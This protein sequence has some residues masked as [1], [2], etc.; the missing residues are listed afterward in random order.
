[1]SREQGPRACGDATGRDCRQTPTTRM[2]KFDVDEGGGG[3]MIR[4]VLKMGDPLLLEQAQPVDRFDT[5]ELQALLARHARHHG[6]P[7]RGRLWPRRRS[8]S[9]CRW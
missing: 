5:P 2:Q 3:H 7:E 1:M 6:A 9:A 8:A 4:E